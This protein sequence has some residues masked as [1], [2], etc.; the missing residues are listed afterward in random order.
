MVAPLDGVA[1]TVLFQFRDPRAAGAVRCV[2][3]HADCGPGADGR[4]AQPGLL[5]APRAIRGHAGGSAKLSPSR[6]RTTSRARPAGRCTAGATA[7]HDERALPAAR[8]VRARTV[9]R[10]AR[11]DPL[12]RARNGRP[13]GRAPGSGL[14]D[15][16]H[17]A[18]ARNPLARYDWASH[19]GGVGRPVERRGARGEVAVPIGTR[20]IGGGTSGDVWAVASVCASPASGSGSRTI[21]SARPRRSAR[22]SPRGRACSAPPSTPA[23]GRPQAYDPARAIEGL[24]GH[25]LHVHLKDVSPPARAA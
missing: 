9:R 23:G 6:L 3:D 17:V 16:R 2:E 24:A 4:R 1:G 15:R 21:R 22:R 11:D 8:D 5:A 14:G 20:L 19:V 10:V 13:R 18:I 7:T 12:A 25:V